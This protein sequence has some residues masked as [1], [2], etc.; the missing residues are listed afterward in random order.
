MKQ[1]VLVFFGGG[2]GSVLR[3]SFTKFL[4]TV[5]NQFPL[6]TFC[7]NIIGCLLIGFLMGLGLKTN[8]LSQ[9]QTILLVTGFCGGFTTFSAFAA[10]N[11]FFLK[12]GDYL[13]F[14]VYTMASI[15]TGILAVFVGLF[16]AK[17]L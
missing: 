7:V 8:N 4:Q 16:I 13:L 1:V 12:S 15:L 3:F 5:P 17:Q 6:G 11:Q 9:S 14:G 2:L 10:E